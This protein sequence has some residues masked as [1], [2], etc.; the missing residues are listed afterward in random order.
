VRCLRHGQAANLLQIRSHHAKEL[1]RDDFL[2]SFEQEQILAR[3]N[4]NA[5]LRIHFFPCRDILWCHKIFEPQQAKRLELPRDLDYITRVVS[6]MAIDG[7][8]GIDAN[9]FACRSDQA[10]AIIDRAIA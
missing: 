5:N 1:Q 9:G 6:P 2:K 7:N 4:R 10:N 3:G 8:I